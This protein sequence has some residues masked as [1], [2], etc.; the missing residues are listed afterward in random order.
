MTAP[1]P[2]PRGRISLVGAGPGAADL[3]TLRALRCLQEADLILY[4]RLVTEDILA[5]IPAAT[6]RIAVG[7]EVGANA[8]PQSRITAL[9]LAEAVSGAHVV[10][11]KSGD[12]TI[13]GR[14]SEEIAGARTLG[15]AVEII[16]GITAASA[17]AASLC[18]SL[19]TRGVAQRL[20]IATATDEADGAVPETL[21]PGTTLAL[22]MATRKLAE[23]EATLLARGADPQTEVAAVCH[24]SQSCETIHLAPLKGMAALLSGKQDFTH[25]CVLILTAGVLSQ[26]AALPAVA[27]AV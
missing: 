18:R 19:T 20:V 1:F 10:R 8:W 16:P 9:M 11:L 26:T 24:A 14:A 3:L 12:P 22:Y 5:L 21:A 27:A 2:P 13:F 17:A 7:K 6:R 23:I 4:D 15:L 25:P